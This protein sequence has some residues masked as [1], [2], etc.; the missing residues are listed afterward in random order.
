LGEGQLSTLMRQAHMT[1]GTYM[2]HAIDD[3]D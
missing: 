2:R 3:I 1:A